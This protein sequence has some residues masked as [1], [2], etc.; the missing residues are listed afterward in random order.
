[1]KR[2]AQEDW[3]AKR[4][5]RRRRSEMAHFTPLFQFVIA[6]GHPRRFGNLACRPALDHQNMTADSRRRFP[7]PRSIN[8]NGAR[9]IVRDKNGLA[10]AY[11]YYEEESGRRPAANLLTRDEARPPEASDLQIPGQYPQDWR[12]KRPFPSLSS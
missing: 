8:D 3:G 9:F 1:V 10:L 6:P 4:W 7:P 2:E 11:C 12:V 5:V